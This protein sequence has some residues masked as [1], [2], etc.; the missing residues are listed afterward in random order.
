MSPQEL[1]K[2]CKSLA[3]ML[4]GEGKSSALAVRRPVRLP[5][6]NYGQA[7]AAMSGARR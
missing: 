1:W 3:E 5:H 2:R 4:T 6:R 7:V